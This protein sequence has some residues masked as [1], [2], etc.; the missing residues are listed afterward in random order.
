MPNFQRI[1]GNLV[2]EESFRGIFS[3]QHSGDLYKVTVN[4]TNS[5]ANCFQLVAPVYLQLTPTNRY[6]TSERVVK[7]EKW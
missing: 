6:I 5:P 2:F 3:R 4:L 7:A 1:G